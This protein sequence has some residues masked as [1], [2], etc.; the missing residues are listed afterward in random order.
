MHNEARCKNE[1]A[2]RLK[3]IYN[4]I[5]VSHFQGGGHLAIFRDFLNKVARVLGMTENE[6]RRDTSLDKMLS[7]NSMPTRPI[8][9][10]G[11]NRSRALDTTGFGLSPS[12]SR[13]PPLEPYA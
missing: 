2:R 12:L 11:F 3:I 8:L 4:G 5:T 13:L 9:Q 7:L 6:S 1:H 10:H